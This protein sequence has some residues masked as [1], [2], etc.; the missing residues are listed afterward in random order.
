L[1]KTSAKH[2]RFGSKADIG[3]RP[4]DVRFTPKSRHWTSV[5]KCPLCAKS[6]HTETTRGWWRSSSAVQTSVEEYPGQQSLQPPAAR[7]EVCPSPE[8]LPELVLAIATTA[9][10]APRKA[11]TPSQDLLPTRSA[12][13]ELR[14]RQWYRSCLR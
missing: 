12:A 1:R 8:W 9:G 13:A 2:I 14:K 7:M 3:A 10:P 4:R 6:R 11:V 5:S